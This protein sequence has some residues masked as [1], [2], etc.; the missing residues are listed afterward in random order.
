M[1]D[2]LNGHVKIKNKGSMRF[3]LDPTPIK[4]HQSDGRAEH[5]GWLDIAKTGDKRFQSRQE[6]ACRI[7]L[8]NGVQL[9]AEQSNSLGQRW[10]AAYE[11][12]KTIFDKARSNPSYN[13]A[14]HDGDWIDNQQLFYLCDPNLHYYCYFMDE[15]LGLCYG[16]VP[17]WCPFRLQFYCNGHSWLARQ[18]DRKQIGYTLMDNAFTAIADGTAA[19][20][21][22]DSW[23]PAFLHRKL[24]EFS[25]RYCPILKQIE[26]SYH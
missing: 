16:H 15:D 19:Q 23:D 26:E 17:T 25:D 8:D 14:K 6:W 3:G 24:D 4:A 5:R 13:L 21:L 12:Q 2:L 22:A 10:S 18:L 7:A 20:S 11:Y 1:Y 9:T